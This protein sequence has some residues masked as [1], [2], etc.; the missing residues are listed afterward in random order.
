MHCCPVRPLRCLPLLTREPLRW[1]VFICL[2]SM[3]HRPL[4]V[5][6]EV[7]NK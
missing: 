4:K 6:D 2:I 1:L 5:R 7:R 3:H